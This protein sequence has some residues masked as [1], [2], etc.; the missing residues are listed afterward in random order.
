[1]SVREPVPLVTSFS[2]D[3]DIIVC[4]IRS[5]PEGIL[6]QSSPVG[7]VCNMGTSCEG[8]Y[9]SGDIKQVVK[10]SLELRVSRD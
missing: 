9:D 1:M 4:V 6:I 3:V 7:G 5:Q 2:R 10:S 8:D